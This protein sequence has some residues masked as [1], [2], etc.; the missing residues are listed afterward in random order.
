MMRFL[1]FRISSVAI[2]VALLAGAC[3]TSADSTPGQQCQ[4]GRYKAAAKYAAC[5]QNFLA[6]AFGGAFPLD[7]AKLSKCRDK[8]RAIFAKLQAK[9]NGSGPCAAAR[10]VDN[11]NGTVTDSLTG[12]QWE[13][14]TNDTTIHDQD[15]S[16]TW[17]EVT[18]ATAADGTVYTTFLPTLNGSCF[19][20]QCDWR[21]PT[22]AELLTILAEPYPCATDPCIDATFG[23]TAGS[24][25]RSPYVSSTTVAG[26]EGYVWM[27]LF[28]NGEI[29]DAVKYS[30]FDVRAVRG[31][32]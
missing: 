10:F 25:P 30:G 28:D 3:P 26:A 6:K 1:H 13:K 4:V 5:H 21:L 19:A 14:K 32:L 24:N 18:M 31:G 27:V 8:Y 23:L 15:N 9:A 22:L 12:L 20:G 2:A 17:T 7:H 11:G 29:V 16:Y